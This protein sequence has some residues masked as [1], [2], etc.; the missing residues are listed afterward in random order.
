MKNKTVM[1]ADDE[2]VMRSLLGMVLKEHGYREFVYAADGRQAVELI[3]TG[4]AAI[5]L[6]FLDIDMPGFSGLDVLALARE[7]RPG[8]ACV[9]VSAHSAVENVMAAV[10]GGAAG[11]VV[12]PY[13][14][15]RIAEVLDKIERASRP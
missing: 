12:K 9:I 2:G 7:R 1:I 5:G 15:Q 14:A 10:R 4:G 13:S 6:A 8:C 11:F 3:R